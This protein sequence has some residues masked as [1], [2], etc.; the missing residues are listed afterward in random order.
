VAD[1]SWLVLPGTPVSSLVTGMLGIQPYPVLVEV[2]AWLCYL[3]P[4]LAY[5]LWPRRP[6]P[7]GPRARVGQAAS[8][9][10]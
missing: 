2:V 6:H 8:S 7:S 5:L 3:V 10:T 1:L 4:L 9:P